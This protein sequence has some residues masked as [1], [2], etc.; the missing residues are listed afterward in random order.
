MV[1]TYWAIKVLH[2]INNNQFHLLISK[3]LQWHA[4]ERY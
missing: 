3:T 1:S 4:N 2:I